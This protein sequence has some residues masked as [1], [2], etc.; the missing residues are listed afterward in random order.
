V[1]A[2][3]INGILDIP[4]NTTLDLL[5]STIANNGSSTGTLVIQGGGT[6]QY[7]SNAKSTY[8]GGTIVN[9]TTIDLSQIP[10]TGGGTS[11]F[12][13][14]GFEMQGNDTVLFGAIQ[15]SS[16]QMTLDPNANVFLN[17]VSD[18]G[19]NTQ[20]GVQ[21]PRNSNV[22][23]DVAN[24][25]DM[26]LN[27]SNFYGTATWEVNGTNGGQVQID[28]P[29]SFTNATLVLGAN[30]HLVT[31]NTD[32]LSLGA[33]SG[34]AGDSVSSQI[35][36]GAG[37]AGTDIFHI[38]VAGL[39]TTFS[40]N[41]VDSLVLGQTNATAIVIDAGT[42][43][44]AGVSPNITNMTAQIAA[45]AANHTGGISDFIGEEW[46]Q[47]TTINSGATLQVGDLGETNVSVGWPNTAG[48]LTDNGLL[49]FALNGSANLSN[50]IGGPNSNIQGSGGVQ[51]WMTGTVIADSNSLTSTYTGS[52]EIDAG[53]WQMSTFPNGGIASGL[54]KSSNSASNVILNGGGLLYSGTGSTTDRSFTLGNSTSDVGGSIV[55]S[56]T[57]ALNFLNNTAGNSIALTT[58]TVSPTFTLD[59]TYDGINNFNLAI[60][61]VNGTV[62]TN[63]AL[64]GTTTWNLSG[65]NTYTG[66]TT[67]SNGNLVITGNLGNTTI[68]VTNP[69][70][71]L[72]GNGT[73]N[74]TI[75]LN[76]GN[77]IPGFS[78]VTD[79]T[80]GTA[81]IG[82][83]TTSSN[84]TVKSLNVTGGVIDLAF[85]GTGGNINNGTTTMF[86][87]VVVNGT[88]GLVLGSGT[89]FNFYVFNAT[90]N[91]STNLNTPWS[92]PGYY[93][94]FEYNGTAGGIYGLNPS[95]LTAA[96]V[97]NAAAT[98]LSYSFGETTGTGSTPPN[99]FYVDI[100]PQNFEWIAASS[101]NWSIASNW[102]N[103][104]VPGVTGNL[105]VLAV[106]GPFN[107]APATVTL[108]V[109]PQLKGLTFASPLSYNVVSSAGNILN[110]S[111]GGTN[112]STLTVTQGNHTIAANT[113]MDA[114]GLLIDVASGST[115]SI[116][117]NVNQSATAAVTLTDSG[118][119]VLSGTSNYT[120]GFILNQGVLDLTTA[121]NST[122]SALGANTN[123]LTI[124]GGTLENT[125]GS[126]VTIA[127]N[128][129]VKI[130][131]FF[132][133]GSGSYDLNL[134]TGA[135][136]L[137]TTFA[138][139]TLAGTTGNF[140]LGGVIS[141]STPSTLVVTGNG[142]TL[143]LNGASTFTG[144][145]AVSGG[146][147][148]LGGSL[149]A[150]LIANGT[151]NV[152][153]LP[154]GTHT[155]G[156]AIF[157]G[158][159]S[160]TLAGS[161]N[162]SPTSINVN[163]TGNVTISANIVGTTAVTENSTSTLTLNGTSSNFTGGVTLSS[164]TLNVA[165]ASALGNGTV[166]LT[167]GTLANTGSN[168]TPSPSMAT[169]LSLARKNLTWV[170]ER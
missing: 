89:K 108:D 111:N 22:T 114:G 31:R 51:D 133:F 138:T 50:M 27:V 107:T 25:L 144:N 28:N 121:G 6:L 134:G 7:G 71:A 131:N 57:G 148:N 123:V 120:G 132:T 8:S 116:S 129:P 117:G 83:G 35:S 73:I 95:L 130:N 75:N 88:G 68:S 150:G 13:S 53:Y 146:S 93:N 18:P 20:Q 154:T 40:G 39:T 63:V 12:G 110:F 142:Q 36:T 140:T 100:S 69:S 160:T 99:F 47:G 14:A 26:N 168:I 128:N 5:G 137:N 124:N 67:V 170:P 163:G 10:A 54:G 166:T 109:S 87:G 72:L 46:T 70:A 23:Y 64:V 52:T 74:G 60:P 149:V 101:G 15:G 44:L 136:T 11:V 165:S 92:T 79:S 167:N 90:A 162:F 82:G 30:V 55:S 4:A 1:S 152:I 169:L 113:T 155:T 32:N 158:T 118:T 37:A 42:F 106:L 76:N 16:N 86:N 85:N 62:P 61:N 19:N 38:G 157:N 145:L 147:L 84:L 164:G 81:P 77:L 102:S 127:T 98:G 151:T 97:T 21:G 80:G 112:A 135:V 161:G 122:A 9:G 103:S 159:N 96:N 94:L 66:T 143:I 48:R 115:L 105:G 45:L 153:T 33:L 65:V 59:G 17:F 119:L 125:I 49:R 41:I 141:D 2:S 43:V 156:A 56:G 139:I 58:T 91:Y 34:P 24:S 126:P 3:T 104:V 29:T 78:T